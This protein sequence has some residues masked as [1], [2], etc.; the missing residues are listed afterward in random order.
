M[1][2]VR[3]SPRDRPELRGE[4]PWNRHAGSRDRPTGDLSGSSSTRRSTS[5]ATSSAR[6]EEGGLPL[7]ESIALYERGAA[8]HEHCAPT[9]RRR[10]APHRS[11]RRRTRRRAPAGRPATRRRGR[12]V[13]HGRRCRSCTVPLSLKGL[14]HAE[15]RAL[16]TELRETII[17]TVAQTGG[18][19]GSSLGVVELT[20][21][22]H[23]VLASPR[24]R[25]VWDTG[26]QAYAHKLLT[27]RYEHFG[28]LRQLGGVGGFPR[29]SE[30]DHDVMDGGHAGTGISIAEGL[31]LARDLRGGTEHVAVVVGDAALMSGLVARGAQRH[32]SAQDAH[33][34]PAQ[35]QR[36]EHLADGRRGEPVPEPHQALAPLA[37]LTTPLGRQRGALPALRAALAGVVAPP[38]PRRRRPLAAGSTLRGPRR[39]LRGPVPGHDLVALDSHAAPGAPRG[40]RADH[41]P[42]PHPQGLRL[43]ARRGRQGQLP[44]RGPAADA[45]LARV[46]ATSPSTR[47]P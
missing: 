19:L 45:P 1:D 13:G 37:R 24:D 41:R 18:H 8:L 43:P 35:R 32:R 4:D 23:R 36:D 2:G 40:G 11:A 25:I 33:D 16:C 38:P 10:G 21:A 26:H 6:L 28:T 12:P 22:L 31:A 30:S 17:D 34:H 46:G 9:A 14:S 7:E 3:D 15:A 44:R 42:R 29:R 20:V 27:G 47:A 5:C 39:H